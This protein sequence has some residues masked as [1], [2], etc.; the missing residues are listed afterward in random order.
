MAH[1]KRGGSGRCGCPW[2]SGPDAGRNYAL[3]P[4]FWT[5]AAAVLAD[6][7]VAAFLAAAFLVVFFA[8]VF[9]ATAFLAAFFTV[10]LV[11]ASSAGRRPFSRTHS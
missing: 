8:A 6:F 4:A 3:P 5:L 1:A 10:F 7:L 2:P 9:V 11:D